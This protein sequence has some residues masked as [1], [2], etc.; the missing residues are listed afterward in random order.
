M[1]GK[2]SRKHPCAKTKTGCAKTG[3]AKTALPSSPGW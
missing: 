3:C 1:P 2:E